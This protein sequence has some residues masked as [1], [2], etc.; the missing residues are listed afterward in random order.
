VPYCYKYV[1]PVCGEAKLKGYDDRMEC[2][3]CWIVFSGSVC[4]GCEY[5]FHCEYPSRFGRPIPAKKEKLP[6]KP[7]G[8]LR[9]ET[10]LLI[11]NELQSVEK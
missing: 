4:R 7:A 6:L 9:D 2:W 1:C 3:N 8:R 5:F 11:V 10:I